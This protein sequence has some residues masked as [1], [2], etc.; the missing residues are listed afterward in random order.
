MRLFRMILLAIV[1]TFSFA[2]SNEINAQSRSHFSTNYYY[3]SAWESYDYVESWYYNGW[4]Q[5]CENRMRMVWT[6]HYGQQSV[7]VW[8]YSRNCFVYSNQNSYRYYWTY[9]WE[10]YTHCY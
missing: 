3:E 8:N 10:R 5:Y 2:V 7:R 6:K 4:N 9:R 1:I